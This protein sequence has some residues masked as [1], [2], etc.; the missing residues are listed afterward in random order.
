M[1]YILSYILQAL[2]YLSFLSD[3]LNDITMWH[4]IVFLFP[5]ISKIVS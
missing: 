2:F 5:P 1:P 3:L 4:A